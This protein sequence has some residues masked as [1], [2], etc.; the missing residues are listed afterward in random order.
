MVL[1]D[2]WGRYDLKI[3]IFI[4]KHDYFCLCVCV[5]VYVCVYVCMLLVIFFIIFI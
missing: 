4:L 1:I 2:V 5:C 3:Y